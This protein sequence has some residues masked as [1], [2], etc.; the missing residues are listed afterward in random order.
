MNETKLMP[1]KF[2]KY[3]YIQEIQ[4]LKKDKSN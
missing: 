1:I 3:Y 4:F 2:L